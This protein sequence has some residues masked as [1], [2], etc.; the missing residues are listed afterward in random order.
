MTQSSILNSPPGPKGSLVGGNLPEMRRGPLQFFSKY[1]RQFGDIFG[2][3]LYH[4]HA[5]FLNHPDYI[6]EILVTNA[7]NIHKGRS[8]QGNKLLFGEGLLTSEGD[9]WLRQRRLSQ[10]A[11]H[12][13]RIAGYAGVMVER[14][15]RMM[16]GWRDGQVCDIHQEMMQVTL[17]IA[18]RTL[19]DV[20]LATDARD[21]A[22]ALEAIMDANVAAKRL[23]APPDYIPTPANVRYRKAVERLERVVYR[24][25]QQHR[26][27]TDH[28]RDLL[29]M[30][31]DARDEDGSRM[32]DRQ[33]RDEVI[34]LLLAGHETTAVALSWAWYLLGQ[35][36]EAERKLHNE[37]DALADH[38]PGIADLPRLR[39]CEMVVNE[40]MRLYPP[41][42]AI[43]RTLQKE[44]KI[45]D[46][47]LPA[48]SSVLMS[49]Y[50]M[51]RDPRYF[52]DPE[53][54]IPQRWAGDF[55]KKLPK[56]AY[57]PFG[58]GPRVCI[59]NAFAMME[60]VLLLASIAQR[61]RIVPNPN[62]TVTPT[63]AI[64]LRPKPGI[65]VT[66]EKRSGAGHLARASSPTS[67]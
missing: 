55:A 38:Q 28:P 63:P 9:F 10:P 6:E 52:S 13:E 58:G 3:R 37:V 49:P 20:D 23:F 22:P 50:V 24:I 30:L 51:H 33:L 64:T 27:R 21:V 44:I 17:D 8:L 57:F 39:Y 42:W 40:A 18:G 12:R 65:R 59:G 16:D 2:Y 36:P 56:F 47:T 48:G 45:G 43:I 54:F 35:N 53:K 19:F 66:L 32:S 26:E 34:T 5:Y 7:R 61:F 41:A 29:S 46:Y 11:F 14:A 25:I 1:A 15:Q 31:L 4:V 62:Q 60:A 67:R